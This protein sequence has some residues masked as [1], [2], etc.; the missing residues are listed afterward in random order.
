MSPGDHDHEH[1]RRRELQRQAA[2]EAAPAAGGDADT[3]AGTD[4]YRYVYHAVRTAPVPE[5]P[6]TFALT[7]ERL[8]A[9]HPEDAAVERW[10][11]RLLGGAAALG[12]IVI[13][14]WLLPRALST[15]AA[16]QETL[17]PVL[18]SVPWPLLLVTCG[19]MAIAWLV[20][21]ALLDRS[22]HG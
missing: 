19:G 10:L 12:T 3:D 5:P 13:A 22:P 14:G 11:L 4:A 17:G 15:M 6:P 7:M 2:A 9:D 16:Q 18:Q 20:D 1:H 21:R 8:A